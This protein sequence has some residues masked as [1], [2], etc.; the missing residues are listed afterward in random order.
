MVVC[1]LQINLSLIKRSYLDTAFRNIIIG[2]YYMQ[3]FL[4]G[5]KITVASITIKHFIHTYVTFYRNKARHILQKFNLWHNNRK[6]NHHPLISIQQTRNLRDN[7]LNE[8]KLHFVSFA[9]AITRVMIDD[10]FVGK[11]CNR[12]YYYTFNSNQ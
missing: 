7:E 12:L 5:F 8:T 1:N 3:A 11:P 6:L 4:F 10:L 9:T 2:L